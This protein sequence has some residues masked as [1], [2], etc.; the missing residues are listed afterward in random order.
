MDD[1]GIVPMVGVAEPARLVGWVALV[2][3][4]AQ[5][6]NVAAFCGTCVVSGV[7][8]AAAL[9]AAGYRL[10]VRLVSVGTREPPPKG[11]VHACGQGGWSPWEG[12]GAR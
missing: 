2:E 8:A 5:L 11:F 1:Y 3:A 10:K 6:D 9:R 4:L 7:M 12:S